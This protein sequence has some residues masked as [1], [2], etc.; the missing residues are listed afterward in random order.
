MSLMILQRKRSICTASLL[1]LLLW[2]LHYKKDITHISCIHQQWLEW[3]YMFYLFIK[4]TIVLLWSSLW[5][6]QKHSEILIWISILCMNNVCM[7]LHVDKHCRCCNETWCFSSYHVKSICN[8]WLCLFILF[9]NASLAN[10]YDWCEYD[11]E[12]YFHRSSAAIA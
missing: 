2:C 3:H 9:W 4:K 11:F 6:L 8:K 10:Y 7:S 12:D 5:S 1:D